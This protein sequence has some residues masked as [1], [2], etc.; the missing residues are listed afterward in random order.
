MFFRGEAFQQK[1]WSEKQKIL[2]AKNLH[3]ELNDFYNYLCELILICIDKNIKL[4]IENPYSQPHYLTSYFPIKPKIIDYDRTKNGDYFKKPTQF[5][6]F[7]FEPQNNIIF[8]PIEHVKTMKI[9]SGSITIDKDK[10]RQTNRSKIHPQ[11]A[12]RFIR[13]FIL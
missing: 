11:Y 4:I 3:N 13:Q 9:C 2:Y 5:Y 12:N 1:R 8:E 6:F 7:N 10:S